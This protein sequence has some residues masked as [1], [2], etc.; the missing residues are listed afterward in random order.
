MYALYITCIDICSI[1]SPPCR[2]FSEA[3][4][5][6]SIYRRSRRLK[7]QT[8]SLQV[9]RFGGSSLE[10]NSKELFLGGDPPHY[11][12]LPAWTA[13]PLSDLKSIKKSLKFQ[14]LINSIFHRFWIPFDFQF[15]PTFDFFFQSV[16]VVTKTVTCDTS[17]TETS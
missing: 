6:C 13:T 14:L 15:G 3:V 12:Q 17:K 1:Y 9:L 7:S 2:S 8:S 4:E 5:A 10:I 16:N 11:L